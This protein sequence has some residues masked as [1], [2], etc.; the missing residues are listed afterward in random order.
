M[1]KIKHSYNPDE[2]LLLGLGLVTTIDLCELWL[3]SLCP[4]E[5]L[6]SIDS[7]FVLF[8]KVDGEDDFELKIESIIEGCND[9]WVRNQEK[10]VKHQSLSPCT[11]RKK[12]SEAVFIMQSPCQA[13]DVLFTH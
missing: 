12:L 5:G 4:S 10:M 8:T 3:F 13:R 1:G 11:K 9:I 2:I 6:T 7:V